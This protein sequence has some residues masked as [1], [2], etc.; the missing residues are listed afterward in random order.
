MLYFS[1]AAHVASVHCWQLV[2]LSPHSLLFWRCLT[3]VYEHGPVACP[4]KRWQIEFI[5]YTSRHLIKG[6]VTQ[7]PV[8]SLTAVYSGLLVAVS[9]MHTTDLFTSTVPTSQFSPNEIP[10][11]IHPK[12]NSFPSCHSQ[13]KVFCNF[14]IMFVTGEQSDH[15]Q[16]NTRQVFSQSEIINQ[17]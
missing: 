2:V 9:T 5:S 14:H 11:Q 4:G 10:Y 8:L 15:P 1:T 13:H 12:L 7:R 17:Q 3:H 6:V 16:S